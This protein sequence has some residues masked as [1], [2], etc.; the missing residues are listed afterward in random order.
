MSIK[1]FRDKKFYLNKLFFN[2][3]FDI[4]A[5]FTRSQIDEFWLFLEKYLQ[6]KTKQNDDQIKYD[7]LM[8]ELADKIP[9]EWKHI[10]ELRENAK[11]LF[12]NV[13]ISPVELKEFRNILIIFVDF[14]LKRKEKKL[15][16]LLQFQQ[17]LP[18]YEYKETILDK[19][20]SNSVVL[21]AGDT[22]CGKSTQVPQY[23]L[24]NGY[25][26]ICCTQPRRIACIALCNRLKF[27]TVDQYGTEIG[28]Q[29]RFEKSKTKYTK[30]IFMT[31]GLLLRQMIEDPLLSNYEVIILDEVHER[32]LSSD[33]LLGAVKCLLHKRKNDLKVI[34]MSATLNCDLFSNYF[35][36]C[37]VIKVP[38][39]LYPIKTEYFPPDKVN[40]FKATNKINPEPY[41]K[42]LQ[43]I[44][45]Q[46]PSTER[47]D[48]LVFLSG[49]AEIEFIGEK[50][51]EYAIQSKRWIIMYLHSALSLVEQD[52][53]FDIS[54]EGFRKCILSTNIAETSITIDGI[55]FVIDSGKV[56]EM[57]Y[58]PKIR[59][60]RLQEIWVSKASAEQRKGRAGRTGPGICFRLYSKNDFESFDNF[61]KP[62]IQRVS[63]ESLILNMISMGLN[64][65]RKF[66]FI[67]APDA[68]IIENTMKHLIN[69]GTLD[70]N[71]NI[72]HLGRILSKLPVDIPIGKMLVLSVCINLY[73]YALSMAACLSVQSITTIRS[74]ND[75]EMLEERKSMIS[76]DGDLFSSMNFYKR[77]LT[78][79]ASSQNTRLWCRQLG[80]EE[81]RFHEITKLR[82]Q[83]E[84]ILNDSGLI[85]KKRNN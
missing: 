52:K 36:N 66:P 37:L 6:K 68:M 49:F 3:E 10:D 70:E 24:R 32:H 27:E 65:V 64:N 47:G 53:V 11:K 23:L 25:Q 7:R 20:R 63:L 26:R 55:R 76:F 77:W 84:E 12:E 79:K 19:I 56:K 1:T 30:I 40:I 35:G 13:N 31:E 43:H 62:E 44:D 54:P 38:G 22:G 45:S 72:T 33:F 51:K 14:N 18:I 74:R 82:R 34:L 73:E 28:Y 41:L 5:Q 85:D 48:V 57:Y 9:K 29:I 67:E 4:N 69:Y 78:M 17:N 59:M 15:E 60:H 39:R 16:K 46:Y 83:F 71:E 21:I 42:I 8:E 80:F 61:S 75:R 2:Y 58:E 81:Q 50:L